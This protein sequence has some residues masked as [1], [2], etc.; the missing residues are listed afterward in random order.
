MRS[1]VWYFMIAEITDGFSPRLTIDAVTP[2][3][4]SIDVGVLDH[5]GERLLEPLHLADRQVELLADAGV[6]RL[7]L[8]SS[9]LAP[10]ADDDG[11]EI[12]RPAARHSISMRQPWPTIFSPPITQSIGMNTSRPQIGSV[13]EGGAATAGGGGRSRR[14]DGRPAPAPP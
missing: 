5:A 8:R 11:S 7:V 12:D 9:D 1:V 13:R 10:A 6:G 2:R 4:A 3:A 14:R